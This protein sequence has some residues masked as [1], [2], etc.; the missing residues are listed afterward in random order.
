MTRIVL[1]LSTLPRLRPAPASRS[2][3]PPGGQLQRRQGFDG[4]P[5]VRHHRRATHRLPTGRGRAAR[6]GNPVPQVL[7][8][9]RV[10]FRLAFQAGQ[11]VPPPVADDIHGRLLSYTG[12]TSSWGSAISVLTQSCSPDR[13]DGPPGDR[14]V[15]PDPRAR[16]CGLHPE[17]GEPVA[18]VGRRDLPGDRHLED[19][20]HVLAPGLRA[21][22]G[23]SV[24]RSWIR[25]ASQPYPFATESTSRP[26]RSRPGPSGVFSRIAK[27]LRIA[28]SS[29]RGTTISLGRCN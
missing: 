28:Y 2:D 6:R 22:A 25:A 27:A 10:E 29:L 7:R 8:R 17:R 4:H 3:G 19:G 21:L 14:R 5:R 24:S 26:G 1:L 20:G 13:C 11:R 12:V 23:L 18:E 16:A 15:R 9:Q